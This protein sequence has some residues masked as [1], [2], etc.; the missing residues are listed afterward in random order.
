MTLAQKLTELRERA[1]LSRKELAEAIGKDPMDIWRWEE[2][3]A[4][5]RFASLRLLHKAF[6]ARIDCYWAEELFE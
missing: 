6:S 2:N 1:G 5:P 3:M 4:T